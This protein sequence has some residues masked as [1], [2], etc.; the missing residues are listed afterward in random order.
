MHLA[1]GA[2]FAALAVLFALGEA[3]AAGVAPCDVY[4]K[5]AVAKAQ[6]AK[7]LACGYDPSDPRWTTDLKGH[8]RWCRATPKDAVAKET[9]QRREQMKFCVTC[10][11]YA[12]QAVASAADNTALK[13]G[14]TGPRWTG[15][16]AAHFA[17]CI[18]QRG[19]GAAQGADVAQSSSSAKIQKLEMAA[20]LLQIEICKQRQTN[21]HDVS[22]KSSIEQ[23]LQ[24][25]RPTSAPR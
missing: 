14:L 24:K 10:R 3:C 9:A 21:L 17:S 13:C 18:A 15:D 16:A 2:A 7:D 8:A 22:S 1:I 4:A 23:K 20:R 5:E 19:N 25:R 12:D 11:V 6:A